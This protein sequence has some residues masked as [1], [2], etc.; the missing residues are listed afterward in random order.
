MKTGAILSGLV[1]TLLTSV[2]CYPQVKQYSVKPSAPLL[3]R[4]SFD[5]SFPAE[6]G[7][8][9][10][11]CIAVYESGLYRLLKVEAV[12][13]NRLNPPILQG[14]L[15]KEELD[16]FRGL[17][18]NLRSNRRQDGIIRQGTESFIADI[19]VEGKSARYT[20][21]DSDYRDPFPGPIRKVVSWLQD[22]KAKDS[23]EFELHE[24]S[25]VQGPCPSM[26]DTPVQPIEAGLIP[27]PNASRCDSR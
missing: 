19:V 20:W 24:L 7:D 5:S 1:L 10:H 9:S 17:L 8:S 27:E 6:A 16:H 4:I 11:I 18:R 21:D 26:N 3:A 22:F 2:I 23:T 14:T 15:S 12:K 25:N 13:A